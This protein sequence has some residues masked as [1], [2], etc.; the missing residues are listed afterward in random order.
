[1]NI[2]N[3]IG[4]CVVL[5]VLNIFIDGHHINYKTNCKPRNVQQNKRCIFVWLVNQ[6]PPFLPYMARMLILGLGF[7]DANYATE[8]TTTSVFQPQ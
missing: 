1:M 8:S 2:E 5:I 3:I 6:A 4:F 7:L